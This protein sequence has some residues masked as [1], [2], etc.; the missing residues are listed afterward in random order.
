MK[1]LIAAEVRKK[2][3]ADNIKLGPGGIR[4]IEFIAQSLQLVRGGSDKHLRSRELQVVLPRLATQHGLSESSVDELLRAYTFLRRLEN[5][6]QA[7]RDQQSHDL[8]GDPADRA[9]L[10][11][12]MNYPD[13]QSLIADLELHRSNVSRQ[14]EKVV[15]RSERPVSQSTVAP[16]LA[17]R[18]ASDASAVEW[19]ELFEEQGFTQAQELSE[20][21]MKFRRAASTLQTDNVGRQ[22][23]DQFMPNLLHA[24]K[25]RSDPALVLT[26]VLN[27]IDRILRR[28]AYVALTLPT[29]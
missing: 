29:Q 20:A 3:L 6:I 9:R 10:C 4:E 27:I 5:F 25:N 17:E 13:W 7:I 22:R 8:P 24:L 15:F 1:A 18:W 2:E 23:L 14:F 28:S 11:L 26:R 16:G 12:A 19:R 21:V